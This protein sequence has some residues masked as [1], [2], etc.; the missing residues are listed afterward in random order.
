[1]TYIHIF[2]IFLLFFPLAL[3]GCQ[4]AP[5]PVAG[6]K[7][8]K[9]YA[10]EG[11]TY[12]PAYDPGYD[13]VGE[14]SWYGPGFHGKYTASGEVFNQDDLTAAH[15][16]LPMPSMVR[17]TNL[18]NGKSIIARVNDRGPF[19]RNRIIDLSKKS[20]MTIGM[21]STGKVRVQYLPE[22]TAQ[23]IAELKETGKKSISMA[24]YKTRK[25]EDIANEDDGQIVESRVSRTQAGDT[26][27]EAAPVQSVKSGTL[28]SVQS[29]DLPA[30]M[31]E[32][33]GEVDEAEEAEEEAAPVKV[34]AFSPPEKKRFIRDET[35]K[36][37][38]LKGASDTKEAAKPA[39]AKE[40]AAKAAT[41]ATTPSGKVHIQ[42]GSFA[43]EENARKLDAKLA[44][45]AAV[46]IAKIQ[47]SGKELWRVR[48]GPF[49]SLNEA[50]EALA[51]VHDAGLPDARITQ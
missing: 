43:S 9:P 13:K 49:A 24:E 11:R 14:A 40:V 27:S 47:A 46:S 10:I 19:K 35:G 51:R 44:D 30:L 16:T 22:E 15:P 21:L 6:M 42:V 50:S 12:V 3:A 8:G 5:P 37:V 4:K 31:P 26:V 45:I 48:L 7:I 39:P 17:V 34:A 18:A 36:P 28:A 2:R 38:Q 23:Y 32:S 20:A 29:N 1:M 25:A 41:V 33:K